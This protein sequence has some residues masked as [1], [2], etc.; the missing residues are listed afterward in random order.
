MVRSLN[1]KCLLNLNLNVKLSLNL[2]FKDHI[3]EYEPIN[4]LLIKSSYKIGLPNKVS[5]S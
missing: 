3:N 1:V 4:Q 2:H 5:I